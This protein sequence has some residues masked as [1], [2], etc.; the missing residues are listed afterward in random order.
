M[1]ELEDLTEE[2]LTQALAYVG[3]VLVAFEL[4]K[5]LIV[6]P[7][8]LFYRDTTFSG[9]NMPFKSYEVDVQSRH[10]DQFEAC[11]LYL[12]DFMQAID[13]D[14][15][16]AIQD[17]RRHRNDLAH[18]LVNRLHNLEI[19]AHAKLFR[20]VD[21]ALFKLSN[22]QTY[23]DIGSVPEYQ[24]VGIDWNTITGREYDIL[25]EVLGK[26]KMFS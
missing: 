1:N 16:K 11:L 9:R 3:L 7:I 8:K 21:I 25:Q 14:N 13:D 19:A 23:M 6:D 10:K 17:L 15:M 26:L 2:E 5:S 24:N 20:D 18:D 12:R 4:V 22:Y